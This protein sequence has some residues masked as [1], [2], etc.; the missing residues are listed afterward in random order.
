MTKFTLTARMFQMLS[1]ILTIRPL[2]QGTDRIYRRRMQASDQE[3]IKR[4]SVGKD[5]VQHGVLVLPCFAKLAIVR[6]HNKR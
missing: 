3:T 2:H 5:T 6:Q 1:M 4:L